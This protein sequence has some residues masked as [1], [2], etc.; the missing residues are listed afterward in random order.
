[1]NV[2]QSYKNLRFMQNFFAIPPFFVYTAIKR[3]GGK[4]MK[5]LGEI[6]AIAAMAFTIAWVLWVQI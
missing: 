2:A 3:T 4:I 1:M 5:V 6:A